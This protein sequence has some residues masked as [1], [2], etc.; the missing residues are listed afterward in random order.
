M[1][2]AVV[3]A[4]MIVLLILAIVGVSAAYAQSVTPPTPLREDAQAEPRFWGRGGFGGHSGFGGM[5]HG[6]DQDEEHGP[7]HTAMLEA[8]AKGLGLLP[9]DLEAR[10]EA[11]ESISEV[12]ESL[13]FSPDEFQ[14]LMVTARTAAIQQAVQD[15]W[16]TQEM[17]D[18]MLERMAENNNA[19]YGFGFGHCGDSNGQSFGGRRGGRG[20]GGGSWAAPQSP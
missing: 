18:A 12:A 17:A 5:M 15:G 14:A 3:F 7:M 20:M 4:G 16:L 19:G 1:K 8:I 6:Y 9:A 11:G 10:L 13:G 2:K